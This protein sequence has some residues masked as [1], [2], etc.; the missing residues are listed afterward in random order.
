MAARASLFR[1]TGHGHHRVGFIEL[2]FDLVFV[3]AITQLSHGLLAHLTL[4]GVAETTVL[5]VAVWWL[6]IY[7][8]W[9]TNW[10]DPELVSVRLLLLAMMAGGLALASA[11]PQ[12]FQ[13]RAWVFAGAYVAMQIGR[14]LFMLAVTPASNMV[15]R[16]NFLR[17]LAWFAFSAPLW[18]AGAMV[19]GPARLALWAVAVGIELLA[20]A[21][22]FVVPGFGAS[23]ITDWA[24][25]GGHM[26]ERC[27]L[28]VIIALG[29]SILVAGATFSAAVWDAPR[30][31]AFGATFVGSAA[32]WWI[33][34]ARGAGLGTA[35][36]TGAADPGL[37][38]RNA[39]TYIHLPIMAGIIV[40]AVGDELVLAHPLGH[41]GAGAAFGLIGGP[42]LF[43]AGAAAFKRTL[44][45]WW[46]PSHTV[47][48]TVLAVLVP[49]SAWGPTW[50]SPLALAACVSA[51]LAAV[52]GWESWSLRAEG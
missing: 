21:A 34:F 45:G 52:A 4:L 16:R 33:Y 37:L 31:L 24:I 38:A 3:F 9:V 14:T 6:W 32:M 12:A 44:R 11:V 10:L 15:L 29:E 42:A 46:Q 1:L 41:V 8:S 50:L 25:E 5:M 39:Y 13:G 23:R 19:E 20:P 26:A 43:L 28:F 49:M 22:R 30:L 27:G 7:T 36:I 40:S 47:G 35:R 51:V 48:L 2:F 17:I 18:L